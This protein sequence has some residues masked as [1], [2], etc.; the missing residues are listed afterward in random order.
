MDNL[1]ETTKNELMQK[2]EIFKR[3]AEKYNGKLVY[4]VNSVAVAYDSDEER[5]KVK[6]PSNGQKCFE[7][8]DSA[9]NAFLTL[10]EAAIQSNDDWAGYGY[11]LDRGYIHLI[12]GCLFHNS[13][14]FEERTSEK[15]SELAESESGSFA[16]CDFYAQTTSGVTCQVT[17]FV[18]DAAKAEIAAEDDGRSFTEILESNSEY[19]YLCSETI[20]ILRNACVKAELVEKALAEKGLTGFCFVCNS[21]NVKANKVYDDDEGMDEE[22]DKEL[23]FSGIVPLNF[24]NPYFTNF[25]ASFIDMLNGIIASTCPY[26]S[27]YSDIHHFDAIDGSEEEIDNILEEVQ[28]GNAVDI[29][30]YVRDDGVYDMQIFRSMSVCGLYRRYI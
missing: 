16:V 24:A 1:F 15:F 19:N 10:S 4:T 29:F 21:V 11:N 2:A 12:S 5:V 6:A 30:T 25:R 9:F 26:D 18:T 20:E 17:L 27:Y 8:F 7:E 23:I 13:A 3:E 14:D 22:C 28:I